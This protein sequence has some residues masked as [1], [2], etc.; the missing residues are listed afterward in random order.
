[1]KYPTPRSLVLGCAF[2]LVATLISTAQ[3]TLIGSDGFG[4]SSFNAPGN[5][6]DGLAP[7]GDTN[8]VTGANRLRT[9]PDGA[10]YTFEGASLTL[11]A[12]SADSL[13]YKGTGA[14]G[15]ITVPNLILD[16]GLIVHLNGSGD[17][18]Q[19]AG[20]ISVISPST[21]EGRQGPTYI[22][23][24]LSGSSTIT[25]LNGTY[26][27]T[28]TGNNS[29]F[30]GK[31]VVG[32]GA[33]VTFTNAASVPGNPASPTPDQFTLVGGSVVQDNAGFTLNQA[34]SGITLAGSATL[35]PNAAGVST[36]VSVPI[37]GAFTLT[38]DGAGT[39]TL[40]GANSF[41]DMILSGATAGSRLNI[42][43]AT[44]IGTGTFTIQNGDNAT[45]DNTSGAPLTLSANNP[46]IWNNNFTF[47]GTT[48]LNLG[49]G[50]VAMPG[51]RT[52]TVNANT[53]TV[54]GDISGAGSLT[55]VGGGMLLLG[56][57][58][59][60]TGTTTVNG[61]TLRVTGSLP[62]NAVAVNSGTLSGTGT[63]GGPTSVSGNVAPGSAGVGTLAFATNLTFAS[64][65][66]TFELSTSAA[67]GNDQVTV[68][69]DL[70]LSSV[71]TIY[72]SALG[73]AANLDTADYVLFQVAG[74]TT[75]ATTPALVWQGTTPGNYLQYTL[76]LVG[77]DV[78]LKYT[79]ATA[80]TVT[81]SASPASA[82]RNQAT[83]ITAVVTPG[84]GA[85]ASV[86]ANVTDI[87]G[88]SM[89]S[90]VLSNANTYT[91]TFVVGP[92]V[93]A[94]AKTITVTVTDDTSPTPLVGNTVVPFT[95]TAG[96]KVWDGGSLVDNNWSS[97]PNWAGDAGPAYSGDS[98]AFAGS[99][100]LTP[101]MDT[102][103]SV[104]GIAFDASAGSFNVGTANSSVLT[105]TSTGG[106][107]NSSANAQ[108]LNVPLVLAS[109]QV[110]SNGAA[111]N[112][113]L[114]GPISGAAGISKTGLGTLTLTGSN[115]YTGSL[116]G[117][118]GTI[119]VDSGSTNSS[120]SYAS[121]GQ[122]GS[123]NATMTLKGT[124]AFRTS[125]DLNVGDIGA[126]TGVLNIQD[127]AY[128]DVNALFV[129][130]ANAS[131]SSAAGTVTQTGGTLLQQNTGIG[132]FTIGG[133]SSATTN[134][135]G[136]YNLIGGTVIAR[137]P[138][139]LSGYGAGTVN[140]SGGTFNA[141]STSGGINLQRFA[142]PGGTY[143]LNGGV[144][145]F[146][147]IDASVGSAD[148]TF[149]SVF[150]FNGGT[151]KPTRTR[152][153]YF[154]AHLSRANI[155][156]G[157]AIIDTAGFD[158][159]IE[160]SLQHSDLGGDAFTDGGLT[161]LGAGMLTL[162]ST[163]NP[164][165][166]TGPTRVLGGTL[167]TSPGAVSSVN[168]LTV[169]NATLQLNL[170][171][172]G[173][174]YASGITFQGSS[175]LNLNYGT[176][177]GPLGWAIYVT[178]GGV[179]NS[180]SV[181]I[182]PTV[183]GLTVGTHT[184]IYTGSSVPTN[185]FTLGTLPPGIAAHLNDSGASLDLV[186]TSAGQNLVW[187]GHNGDYSPLPN[188]NI[189]SS[190]NWFD[191]FSYGAVYKEYGL[192]GDNVT[193]DDSGNVVTNVNLT[194]N[195]KPASIVFNAAGFDY[196][197]S[198]SG[199]IGG[200]GPLVKTN[201]GAVF[202]AT[203]NAYAGG[204]IIGGG[205]LT[206]TNNNALGTATNSVTLAG[207]TL[208]L[209]A[210]TSARAI[211][212]TAESS[213]SV[214]TNTSSTLSGG[215]S[216]N[217]TLNKLDAGTLAVTGNATNG[218]INW[219]DGNGSMTGS[220]VSSGEFRVGRNGGTSVYDVAPTA[221]ILSESYLVVGIGGGT[222]T[223]NIN[224]G[225]VIKGDG[226]AITVGASSGSTGTLHVGSGMLTNVGTAET[227]IGE[228]GTGY[229]TQSG[230]TTYFGD[231][232]RI[233]RFSSVGDLNISGGTLTA[234]YITVGDGNN[235]VA[236]GSAAFT[237]SGSSV[238]N[239]MNGLRLGYAGSA[240]KVCA[241]TN[242]GGTL[243]IRTVSGGDLEL[244]RWDPVT[245]VLTLN[246]GAI[247]LLNNASIRY[248]TGNNNIGSSTF[249]QSG[250]TVTFYSDGGTTVGGT[251]VMDLAAD[252]QGT[253][254][255]NLAGGILT[256]P[257]ILQT[258]PAATVALNLN[259]GTLRA[260]ASSTTF[261]QGLTAAN[262]QAGGAFIDT[263]GS[264]I[265]IAQ[266]L[267]AAGGGLVKN[268]AGTLALN[269]PNTY[270]GATTV[271]AGLLGGTG[272]INSPV[273]VNSGAGIAPGSGGI[274]ALTVNSNLTLSANTTN[275]FEVNGSS[276]AND[277]VV[278]GAA[279][280]Y[281]GVLQIT[282]SGTFSAGQSFTLFSGAGAASASS[283]AGIAGSP[284]AGL[285]FSFTNGVLSVVGGGTPSPAMLTNSF[286]PGTGE[287][288]LSWP[289]D[290]GWRLQM[291]STNV[292]VGL[293]TNWVYITDSSVSSTNITVDTSKGT[294]FYRLVYP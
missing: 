231:D 188:W 20:A 249:Q 277:S 263:A 190:P 75:M 109:S 119:V 139:R 281:G 194:A 49:A 177:Y 9:P 137:S 133:R 53:L 273:T 163:N 225:T 244:G 120:T 151:L 24:D 243:N 65:S 220:W 228:N 215:I 192:L 29:A 101:N 91:N 252:G 57:A 214:P 154:P 178:G 176:V 218:T 33:L 47:A 270:T 201:L 52:L 165:Y 180:G 213:I 286:N 185:G 105:L 135:V 122:D 102:N 287:L 147:N 253:Y 8:Y 93:T 211:N 132:F 41:V 197:I 186:V 26:G 38:K 78:V 161:K 155:R 40:S 167:A 99:T 48:N 259:G 239:A 4:A 246:S 89:G 226:E 269:G 62:T 205:R 72:I 44:A 248:G 3:V 96:N 204:T 117:K 5:W 234:N 198:G 280:T 274:G 174:L 235:N 64:G 125:S 232:L 103:Y 131:G 153:G 35:R 216:G 144:A 160:Q 115:T 279:V 168:E 70:S 13:A 34:N 145:E 251:G 173:T 61:G 292:A 266:P 166:Y 203:S 241:L 54:G 276:V 208:E 288:T 209:N 175:V 134:G 184:L 94:G 106:I 223:L 200:P 27:V 182:I 183:D 237:L 162:A 156:D 10:S 202:L 88:S 108:T 230:G 271:N 294:V 85:I 187:Q 100:R 16:G 43:S 84:S 50:A 195:V 113:T 219:N 60:Y 196:T 247:N 207:G 272:T 83:K 181:T 37:T 138:V 2:S 51:A 76:A 141:A 136:V 32:S 124:G 282:P 98:I 129:G 11:N 222:G 87:G 25:N 289:A 86:T 114:A 142:G 42:N 240:A 236:T 233:S 193:F 71:D 140:Q 81:A 267:L 74:T 123:D 169:S 284:G 261:L 30:T 21:I 56:G 121:I 116:F 90:L 95:V 148:P 256:V 242:N 265:A 268:G 6:S 36:V 66:A 104:T 126:S 31:L 275:V 157:G 28:Y 82:A 285:S 257:R 189:N 80:P 67:G 158:V 63:V 258:D 17:I 172:G 112:L 14:A 150:N 254:S 39:L 128:L 7:H 97:N 264:D 118:A 152:A 293:N 191:G 15:V 18:F 111:G 210:V 159:S 238:V 171:S 224:G 217:Y 164:S 1:M 170:I 58:N 19:L 260:A 107:V 290:Q 127:N 283:F 46:M 255:Y 110:V 221:S 22:N 59:T 77:N 68:A 206:V 179:T 250:G 227:W 199:S 245:V 130:S 262:V 12:P 69:A 79:T 149:H 73:G 146:D 291:Q 278:L 212:L 229:F 55:K 45:I 143:N 23:A 92:A